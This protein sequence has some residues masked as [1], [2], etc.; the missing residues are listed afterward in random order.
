MSKNNAIQKYIMLRIWMIGMVELG[1][2]LPCIALLA[3]H[4]SAFVFA[5]K[6]KTKVGN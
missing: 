3:I 5:D 1:K 2:Q 6:A 4:F